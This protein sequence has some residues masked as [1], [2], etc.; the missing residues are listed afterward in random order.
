[1]VRVAG[2]KPLPTEV[3]EQIL[4][5]ADGVPLFVEELTQ[6]VLEGGLL[7]E[8]ADRYVL[9][10]PLPA[11]AVP[12]TLQASLLA[13]LDRLV[14]VREVA[15]AGATIGREFGY[16]LVAAA[17]GLSGAALREA[18]AGLTAAGLVQTCGEPPEAVYTFK[19]ALVQD[20]AYSTLLR[21]KRQELHGR[22]AL[23]LKDLYPDTTAAHPEILAHHC[24]QA[25]IVDEAVECWGRAGQQAIGRSAMAEAAVHLR[26]ALE[27]LPLLP[28]TPARS[29][30][31]IKLLTGL[32]TALIA[33]K[34]Y[35]P[36]ETGRV[37][38]RARILCERLGDTP[39]LIRVVNGQCA[40][41][42][43]RA[44]PDVALRVS[45]DLLRRA[46]RE[47]S[48]EGQI[49][50]HR[51]VGTSLLQ[52]PD[53]HEARRHLEA[54]ASLV[55]RVG[56]DVTGLAGGKDA[57]VAG[58]AFHAIALA[59]LG[60]YDQAKAQI[61]LS[62][63]AAE[64]LTQPHRLAFARA[65][66][67]WFHV[68][69]NEDASHLLLALDRLA[70]EKNFPYW[71]GYVVMYRGLALARAGET[72]EGLALV[73][74]GAARHAA[75]GAAWSIPF[76]LGMAAGLAGGD[77]GLALLEDALAR[78]ERTGE[79]WFEAELHRIR[80]K[81]LADRRDVANA[82]AEYA[83]ALS[84]ARSHGAKHWEL[85]AATSL[86]RLWRNQGRAAD[87]RALLAPLYASFVEG[88]GVPDL[89]EAKALL[90]ELG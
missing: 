48:L 4:G 49:A 19:H 87:A 55:D 45:T 53:L 82:E 39:G 72:S 44:E 20:A 34:G 47:D 18:L 13:R 73:R 15:Q 66:D 6:A 60:Y 77:E 26:K 80:G 83:Q 88:F 85:R 64:R 56:E 22:I 36:P 16:D 59:F 29:Q 84:V 27:L 1:M 74:E 50:G 5:K 54:A 42:F 14:P 57:L 7:R 21:A 65:M 8:E 43:L 31:E 78:V 52:K 24:A 76:F 3:V 81:L 69:L 10:G 28:D 79:R 63:A 32:G 33:T 41:H 9:D 90:D 37:Y 67:V 61:A 12:T 62:V 25:S 89:M 30:Q 51:L 71:A 38:E 68:L 70:T 86:A 40:Y 17:S 58:Y 46:E 35:T 75:A 23:A 2:G 11:L